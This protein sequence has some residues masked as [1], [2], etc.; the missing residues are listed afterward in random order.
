MKNELV[1]LSRTELLDRLKSTRNQLFIMRMTKKINQ[2][3]DL[4]KYRALRKDIARIM[5]YLSY[6]V[7]Q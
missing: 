1:N 5:F 3:F 6:S 2:A 7:R 4:K